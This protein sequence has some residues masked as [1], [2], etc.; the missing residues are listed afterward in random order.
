MDIAADI[1][2]IVVAALIGAVIAQKLR[3]PLILGY[4][5]AGIVVGL[6][7][8]GIQTTD[9]HEIDLLAEI[10]VALLLFAL[11]LAFSL[12]ELQPVKKIA[13]FGTP[14]QIL[15][16]FSFGYALDRYFSWDVS[17]SIWFG[18]LI[19]LSS[20][21]VVLKT[22]MS[23]GLMGTLSKPGH[24]RYADCPGSG[25]GAANDHPAAA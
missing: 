14:I 25:G 19:S 15:L 7:T 4:I 9:I 20:T 17:K 12:R 8:A 16:T 18:G 6:Y 3:Q 13:L 23:R 21:M 24:D 22:L 5:F 1:V 11:G 2:I 10:G